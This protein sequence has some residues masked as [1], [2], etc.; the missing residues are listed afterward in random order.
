MQQ[1]QVNLSNPVFMTFHCKYFLFF[2]CI[3][4]SAV[5]NA[6][7]KL[8][9]FLVKNVGGNRI[10]IGWIN[11]FPNI[12]QISIQRSHDSLRNYKTILS[13]AD[14]KA[15]QNG[16]ADTKAL[17]DHMY[18][19]LFYAME[20]GS[21]YFTAAMQPI[22]DTTYIAPV[23]PPAASTFRPN[24]FVPSFYVYANTHGYVFLNLPDADLKK[25][26]IKFFEEDDT[27]L[28]EIKAVKERALTL[29]K[30]N[31]YKAGWYKFELYND[32]KLVERHKFYL[33]RDF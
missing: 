16:Y 2:I 18:Y 26:G 10:I 31:F 14:P 8:P 23:P 22:L 4:F 6:Q 25:Y 1:L 20:G 32:E 3:I 13:V 29:D 19:R 11:D 5:A 30:A 33:S 27:F 12:S 28:F 9:K 7:D 24:G 15:I 17:N 21:F